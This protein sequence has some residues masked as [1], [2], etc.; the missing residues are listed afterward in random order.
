[1]ALNLQLLNSTPTALK[2]AT[3][4]LVLTYYILLQNGFDRAKEH[5]R[6]P[7]TSTLARYSGRTW[8]KYRLASTMKNKCSV[9]QANLHNSRCATLETLAY[10]RQENI[11]IALCQEPYNYKTS[12]GTY[13]IPGLMNQRLIANNDNR[14]F[15]AVSW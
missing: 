5:K 4:N 14:F 11:D 8:K 1:M 15:L 13:T 7:H 9:I 6:A 12:R 3:N 10:I 2:L